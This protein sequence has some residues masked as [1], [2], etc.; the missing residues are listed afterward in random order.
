MKKIS[1]MMVMAVSFFMMACEKSVPVSVSMPADQFEIS[2][3]TSAFVHADTADIVFLRDT[4]ADA[5]A[6]SFALRTTL[7]LLL[8]ST[9]S[10][11][12]MEEAL[13]LQLT[14]L[15]GDALT[16][17]SPVDSLL[18]DSLI[19]FLQKEPGQPITIDFEGIVGRGQMIKMAAG[20]RACMEGFS[21]AFADPE[22]NY[23]LREYRKGLDELL[24]L[25]KEA[26]PSIERDPF[27]AWIYVMAITQV[28]DQMDKK[29]DRKLLA[30]KDRMSVRQWELYEA[31]HVEMKS[32]EN[33]QRRR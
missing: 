22:A 14:S 3:K 28:V 26:K 24:K 21:F 31:Y 2:G 20:V 30:M 4:L 9:F 16:T 33:Y 7:T 6:D 15:E 17:L 5:K 19:H 18:E 13:S 32:Y 27:S 8:D 25:A 1:M 12:K 11:D 23:L 29:I 10:S